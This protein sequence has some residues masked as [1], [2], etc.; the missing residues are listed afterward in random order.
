MRGDSN[1]TQST[2]RKFLQRSAVGLVTASAIGSA[3]ATETP[4]LDEDILRT[5]N[6]WTDPTEVAICGTLTDF[7]DK[8]YVWAGILYKKKGTMSGSYGEEIKLWN[9]RKRPTKAGQTDQHGPT[10]TLTFEYGKEG[11]TRE[12]EE[13]RLQ[14]GNT[15]TYHATVRIPEQIGFKGISGSDREFTIPQQEQ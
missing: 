14:P 5:G 2:R 13:W 15:Y 9:P 4:R 12:S 3:Q 7:L 11:V 10:F 8:D 1:A 6:A